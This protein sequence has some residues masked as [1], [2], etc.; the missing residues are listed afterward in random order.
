MK[1]FKNLA[2]FFPYSHMFFYLSL[3]YFITLP[4]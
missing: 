4:N 3:C 2:Y 1:V